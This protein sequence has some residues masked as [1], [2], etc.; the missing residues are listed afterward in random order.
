MSTH[1]PFVESIWEDVAAVL[2]DRVDIK[3][4]GTSKCMPRTRDL[5]ETRRPAYKAWCSSTCRGGSQFIAK[6]QTL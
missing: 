4:W 3:Y 6:P 2:A 5:S 1:I